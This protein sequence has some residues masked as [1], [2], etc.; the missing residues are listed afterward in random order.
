MQKM[1]SCYLNISILHSKKILLYCR[2]TKQKGVHLQ[3]SFEGGADETER[4][5][6]LRHQLQAIGFSEEEILYYFK[7][8]AAGE[9]SNLE[10][11]R[12]LGDKRKETLEQIHNLEQ[13]VMEMDVMRN[14]IRKNGSILGGAKKWNF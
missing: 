14:E 13:N 12:M 7:L 6:F 8:L 3:F 11:L 10:R 5:E 9:C 2:C 1:N 4:K